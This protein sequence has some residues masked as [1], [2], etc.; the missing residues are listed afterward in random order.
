[1]SASVRPSLGTL[2]VLGLK[3]VKM[4][5]IPTTAYI[6]LGDRCRSNCSFCTQRRENPQSDRL[7]RVIWPGYDEDALIDALRHKRNFARVCLQTLDYEGMVEDSVRI[8]GQL[9]DIYPVSVSMVPVPEEDMLILRDAGVE[10][11]S[12]ALDAANPEIFRKIKGKGTGNKFTWESHWKAL[13]ASVN[14]FGKGNTH[15][16]VG[17]GES[18]ED[19]IDVMLKLRDTGVY[20]ALFAYTPVNGGS[21][22]NFGRYRAIQM[23]RSL[24]YEYEISDFEFRDGKIV[25]FGADEDVMEEAEKRAFLTSGCPGCNRP[26]YNERPGRPLYNYPFPPERSMLGKD[27]E[28]MKAYLGM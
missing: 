14:I 24:I 25:G 10:Y 2:G 1:M 3:D 19:L 6:M 7:S 12:I 20:T 21:P 13:K 22:P 18:D 5:A 23:A 17:L 26:F 28:S 8:A 27:I 9:S 4:S 15:L 16:I 11:M